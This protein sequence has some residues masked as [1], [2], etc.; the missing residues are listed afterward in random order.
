MR[1]VTSDTLS[2]QFWVD[3]PLM[4]LNKSL[5]R[6]RYIGYAIATE[7]ISSKSGLALP[8]E[9]WLKILGFVRS[10]TKPDFCYVRAI[11]TKESSLG[12]VLSCEMTDL[13]DEPK[14]SSLDNSTEVRAFE[15]FLSSPD[16]STSDSFPTLKVNGT[17]DATTT[18]SIILNCSVENSEV[19][20][21]CLFSEVT[22]PDVIAHLEGGRC[23]VCFRH[24][25]I[26]PGC[27]GGVAQRFDAFM[28]CGVELACP[29]CMGLDF[30]LDDKAFLRE[31]YW[32]EASKAEEEIRQ[33]KIERRLSELG[34]RCK[35]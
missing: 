21:A 22:V 1:P 9:V 6:I 13:L 20:P 16:S 27:T 14:C 7:T 35:G 23:S 5:L 15:Q 11:S 29:L 10:G 4:L 26:C 34:Y 24:R 32:E 12:K 18:F 3:K 19:F 33:K 17:S 30:M 31:Y 2:A 28:G 25:G 8:S